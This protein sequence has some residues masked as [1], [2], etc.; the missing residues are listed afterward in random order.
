MQQ[1]NDQIFLA[2]EDHDLEQYSI[3]WYLK[4]FSFA[5]R[6]K[7]KNAFILKKINAF[8]KKEDLR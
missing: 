3:V 7:F 2:N 8:L 4:Y 6:H 1:E 5:K